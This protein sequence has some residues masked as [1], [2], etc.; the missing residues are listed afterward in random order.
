MEK[1]SEGAGMPDVT[2]LKLYF[3]DWQNPLEQLL[4]FIAKA[5][6]ETDGEIRIS[7]DGDFTVWLKVPPN[8]T[9]TEA[10][11]YLYGKLVEHL[12]QRGTSVRFSTVMTP[13]II[14][15]PPTPWWSTLQLTQPQKKIYTAHD[16][17]KIYR[18]MGLS[19]PPQISDVARVASVAGTGYDVW[20]APLAGS[21]WICV[22]NGDAADPLQPGYV[23]S[24]ER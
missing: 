19:H 12:D 20:A 16:L 18:S 1:V 3:Y 22:F 9:P 4:K 24:E 23:R 5:E 8:I 6:L 14:V 21:E 15:P 13:I 17:V 7:P 10:V 11:P 2:A